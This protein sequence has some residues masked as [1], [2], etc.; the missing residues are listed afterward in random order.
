MSLISNFYGG[1]LA[2]STPK[3]RFPATVNV[4]GLASFSEYVMSIMT[5][6]C[7]TNLLL[8]SWQNKKSLVAFKIMPL[9]DMN[10]FTTHMLEVINAHMILRKGNVVCVEAR[11]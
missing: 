9:E 1:W 8:A 3:L 10:E 11:H 4:W 7:Q 5:Q 6:E 2:G